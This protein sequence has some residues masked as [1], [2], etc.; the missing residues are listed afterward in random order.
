MAIYD[1][2]HNLLQVFPLMQGKIGLESGTHT[3]DRLIHC[4]D[5]G[6]IVLHWEDGTDEVLT[7]NKYEDFGYTG[8]ITI[9]SGKFHIC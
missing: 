9:N 4:A 2:R 6:E 1:E 3:V 5:D 8:E 7:A